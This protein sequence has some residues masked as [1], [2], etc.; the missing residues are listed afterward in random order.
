MRIILLVLSLGFM[1]SPAYALDRTLA[2]DVHSKT[3]SVNL[4]FVRNEG[5]LPHEVMFFAKTFGGTV[6][7]TD[8][9]RIVY[10]IP[11]KVESHNRN[12][13]EERKGPAPAADRTPVSGVAVS[14][15]FI[16]G[17]VSGARPENRTTAKVSYFRS[18][19]S[20][21]W[22]SGIGAY[23]VVDLGEV[24]KGI[25]VKLKAYGNNVE[26]LFTVVPGSAPALIDIQLDGASGIH[27]NPD[28][29]LMAVTELGNISYTKPVA[30]QE[31]DGKKMYVSVAYDVRGDNRYG[32]RV[33][34]YD[35][36]RPLVIDPLL[37]S[38]FLGSSLNE[39]AWAVAV[40]ASGNI[41]IAG[42]TASDGFPVTP[43]VYDTTLNGGFD[44][45]VSKL[46]ADLTTLL[47]STFIGGATE[48][49]FVGSMALDSADNVIVT[50]YTYATDFP[51]TAG[52]YD[53][54]LGGTVDGF[55]F[56]MSNDLTALAGSTYLGG[57]YEDYAVSV[58][59]DSSD[60][61]IVGGWTYS[62]NFPVTGGVFDA[63]KN[64]NSTGFI[65]K[66]NSSL[67]GI[68][69]STF[70]EGSA[71][72]KIYALAVDAAD[73]IYAAGDTSSTNFPTTPGAYDQTYNANYYDCFISKL[74]GGLTSLLAS[75]YLSGSDDNYLRA[76]VIDPAGDILVTGR[77]TSVDFPT[78]ATAY[79]KVNRGGLDIYVSRLDSSLSTLVASTY[80]GG[81]QNDYAGS[82]ALDA[83]GNVYVAGYTSS[84]D[85]PTTARAFDRSNTAGVYDGLI[86]KLSSDLSTLSA[87]TYIGGIYDDELSAIAVDSQGNLYV[88]G[89]SMSS[90]FP[91]TAGAFDTTWAG[92]INDV[93]VSKFSSDLSAAITVNS[94]A[95]MTNNATV[96][97]LLTCPF[98]AK[99]CSEFRISNDGVFDTE[100]AEPFVASKSWSLTA[101]DGVKTV[102]ALFKQG[103]GA[104]SGVYSD[105]I[106]LD[107]TPPDTSI[108]AS[109]TDPSNDAS[110]SFSF[111]SADSS[112][113]FQCKLDAGAYSTC[114]SPKTY[115]G[116]QTGSHTFSVRAVDAAGNTDSTPAV[117]AWYVDRTAPSTVSSPAGGI[118]N[119][120]QTVT[121]T[122]SDGAGSG[123]AAT[124]YTVN[125]SV[126]TTASTLYAGPISITK[127]T[128][129][130]Y[131]SKDA[132]GN[133]EP[134][135]P[136][137][138]TIDKIAPAAVVLVPANISTVN[139]VVEITGTASDAPPS[140]GLAKVEVQVAKDVNGT[141]YYLHSDDGW[142]ATAAWLMATGTA[143]WSINTS[144]VVWTSGKWYTIKARAT[145]AAGN[146]SLSN[147]KFYFYTG[148]PAFSDLTLTLSSQTI[149][150][151]G[152]V[153]L[154]GKLTRLPDVG[155]D[156]SGM[157]ITFTVTDPD[158]LKTTL[159]T[160]TYDEFGH[161]TKL[162]L[163][164]F[165]KKGTYKLKAG[166]AGNT[167]LAASATDVESI[168]VGSSAG[169][170]IIVEGKISNNEGLDSHNKTTN[171]IYK[172]LKDR[173]FTDANI[174][175]LNYDSLQT[176]IVVD[177]APTK[178]A[179]QNAITTWALNRLNAAAAPFYLIMVDHGNPNAFYIN[180]ETITP[181]D[182]NGWMN[183]LE[184]GLNASA[185]LERRAVIIG[186]C[187]SGS[188]IP[189]LSKNGRL[190]ITSAAADEESY[191]GPQEP[192]N[193]RSGEFF[194]DELFK[195]L[196]RGY[197][198]RDS[199]VSATD[200]TE[201]Y[202]LKGGNTNNPSSY[203]DSSV[204]HPLLDDDADGFG[205]NALSDGTGDGVKAG[206]MY[207]G[208]GV[209][210]AA[211]NP[212]EFES[213]TGTLY[214]AAAASSGT[215]WGIAADNN[216]VDSA[217]AEIRSLAT[218]LTGSGG[219]G[220]LEL[221]IPKVV[222]SYNAARTRWEAAYSQFT[223]AG[224][225]EIFY[226][227][228]RKITGEI[229]TMKRS[230]VYKN[231]AGN[232]APTAFSLVAPANNSEQ[233]TVLMLDWTDSSDADGLTY[234]VWISKD[235]TF[236]TK[237]H[238]MEDIPVSS[239]IIGLEANLQDLTTYYW[240]VFAVDSYGSKR[241][242]TQTWQFT[243]NNTNGLPAFI[244]GYVTDASTGKGIGG[245]TISASVGGS[246]QTFS[247]GYY[248]LALTPNS[249]TL[250]FSKTGYANITGVPV[251]LASGDS[252]IMSK[253]LTFLG[254]NNPTLGAVTPTPITT[255]QGK[256]QV[257]TA[258]YNDADGYGNLKTVEMLV[259]ISTAVANA[260]RVQYDAV[261]N[262]LRMYNNS[263]TTL[264]AGTCVPG[265]AGTITN[266]QGTLNCGQSSVSGAG[267]IMT[268][269]FSITPKSVFT[270]AKKIYTKAADKAAKTVAWTQKGAWT[271]LASNTAPTL[272]TLTHSPATTTAGTAHALTA[273]YSDANGYA[274][275][276]SVE[277]LVT[278]A[279]SGGANSIWAKYDQTLNRLY[280]YNDAGTALLAAT[281]APAAAGKTVSN[282]QGTLNCQQTTVTKSGNNLTVNWNIT[283]KAAFTGAKNLKMRATDN[284]N[285]ATALMN[286]GTWTITAAAPSPVTGVEAYAVIRYGLHDG[287]PYSY[288]EEVAADAS[289]GDLIIGMN[290]LPAGDS[291]A[292]AAI[293]IRKTR[294]TPAL[295]GSYIVVEQDSKTEKY[296]Y[297]FNGHGM[298]EIRENSVPVSI[299]PY[300][301]DDAGALT[302]GR[303]TGQV[304]QD[305]SVFVGIDE[306]SAAMLVGVKSGNSG[307]TGTFEGIKIINQEGYPKVIPYTENIGQVSD[308]PASENGD[309]LLGPDTDASDGETGFSL[310]L[311][312]R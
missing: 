109:P 225:Y 178:A 303:F 93:I 209:T 91:V 174:Y 196:G 126:P 65:T 131:R 248:I 134:S 83:S 141:T 291:E 51:V 122:C 309:L 218:T 243:T 187:Y 157:T 43:G 267:N 127:N 62:S 204:Q 237:D 273:V 170:A 54:S 45:F 203:N 42:E 198:F 195:D 151:N 95:E 165:T 242:S 108:T 128:T 211:T 269:K 5:Q 44:V 284:S 111:S 41:F 216:E 18:S 82:I 30:Y 221:D 222:M 110:P 189:V 188:F 33:G 272:G 19:D 46:N 197:S 64:G 271:I 194:I 39:Y 142:Y 191:K 235:Q 229:S 63:S 164:G 206:A 120:D 140:S 224:R 148:L 241:Q 73:N 102:Y 279:A 123:C 97:L 3:A 186:A 249:I 103:T 234:T 265:A 301:V 233:K 22:K 246:T 149:L 79:K 167:Y 181:S 252:V 37:A 10:S 20:S 11:I 94:G 226:F 25:G 288:Q 26:K 118:Y 179:V 202:T 270:G 214:L 96:T 180:N 298:V 59:V 107:T 199:F 84:D 143:S 240:R 210:N 175:Y 260:I 101:G 136:Q 255:E 200:K 192:D 159:S 35:K 184:T 121:L 115:F 239:A 113:T 144:K 207:L 247:D 129:L 100:V 98:A 75:T 29:E 17:A 172:T 161:Y 116:L 302:I 139:D 245:A 16:N 295:S 23:E 250:S 13:R 1:I 228:K 87:S 307:S 244:S 281:C 304:M 153:D 185:K 268:V 177:G 257:F 306:G 57:A 212:A 312:K 287:A 34:E 277:L 266:T 220:Q 114:A 8:S 58:A 7:V 124:Y 308:L 285:A 132:V 263:G 208:V 201:A 36:D 278:S 264:L 227:T 130:K 106:L 24:Y 251:S 154:T 28:G 289:E 193:I 67:T 69:A 52:A 230:I 135:V 47:A 231:K 205:S 311:R 50:G 27:L 176:G 160:T 55:V 282:T 76:L 66:L 169:Y 60:N 72:N 56:K 190:I 117:F 150:N 147:S 105:T 238:I 274:N 90:D 32:F 138:Y 152:T 119:T 155:V 12:S 78:T 61:V 74:N 254:A 48:G 4:P 86:S 283:P 112:A 158:G 70:L 217:W 262:K 49:D 258:I 305:G 310:M 38:T 92:G 299:M 40:D 6:F 99:N 137:T 253:A 256:A 163:T 89:H 182:L 85:Y 168:L 294:R 290:V 156:L 215:L 104:W 146:A 80:I 162:A 219:T 297:R 2:E 77:T 259:N 276:K 275:L 145:D 300:S 173:G 183:T 213:V 81:S 166:F 21:G 286:K 280:L 232:T 171:R 68:V 31:L 71:N 133:L 293:A 14:E 296:E 261:A 53:S 125:G 223:D 9:G 88:T 15:R 292:E 236:T